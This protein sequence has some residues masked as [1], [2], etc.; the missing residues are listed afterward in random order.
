MHAELIS[1]PAHFASLRPQW[2][3]LYARST[4]RTPFLSFAWLD[5]AWQ[6]RRG[7]AELYLLCVFDE[8]T[9]VGALPLVRERIGS[10]A[11]RVLE[12]LAVPYTQHCDV[13][14]APEHTDVVADALS[15][16][17]AEH[18][19]QWHVLRL[20]QLHVDG[21]ATSA[22]AA[23]LAH[24]GFATRVQFVTSNPQIDLGGEWDAF[25]ASRSRRLRKAHNL[26]ANR[27]AR[28]GRCEVHWLAPDNRDGGAAQ[29]ALATIS[30]ISAR[31]WKSATG[32]SLDYPRARAF[33]QRLLAHAQAL[34]WLSIWQ[35]SLNGWPLAMEWQL[36]EDGTVYALCADF[37][38]SSGRL[39]P[40]SYLNSCLLERLFDA[41]MR[42]YVMGPGDN[43][44][45]YR[46]CD[47]ACGIYSLTAYSDSATGRALAAWEG[48][49]KP[50]LA[51]TRD[52]AHRQ[53]KYRG[54][55]R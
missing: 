23:A 14:V 36:V 34:G 28:S 3:A 44:Y 20:R 15:D 51:R 42:R 32:N 50:W 5:A 48:Y 9:L 17:L 13:L 30:D 12:F 38:A 4:A 35:L 53:A 11:L 33:A 16:A 43:P 55:K 22:L 24:Y 40:G 7:S 19:Q 10:P 54:A 8:H 46:W 39:S 21:V 49:V 41:R 29:R 45:K 31:S 6:W 27:L 1:D 47:G 37:D 25:Y 2:D 18:R 52:P 26:A